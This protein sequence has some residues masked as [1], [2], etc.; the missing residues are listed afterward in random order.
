MR[1]DRVSKTAWRWERAD[2][3]TRLMMRWAS[4]LGLGLLG[5]GRAPL[6][7]CNCAE[8]HGVVI[9]EVCSCLAL[10]PSTPNPAG[11]R[12]F[13]L[14]G[15][16]EPDWAAIDGALA[17]GDV[18]VR[19][20]PGD[21]WERLRILRTDEGPHRLVLDGGG[22]AERATVAGIL[23]PFDEGPRHRITIR[24]FE[25]TGS[26]DKGVFWEAGDD[27]LIEDV[28]IHNNRG[29]PALNLEYSNRSGYPSTGFV[30]RNS[31][32]YDQRGECLYIGGAEGMDQDSHRDVRIENN[33]IHDCW[34]A[35]TKHDAINVK[36]RLSDVRVERNVVLRSDWGIEVASPGIYRNNLVMATVR[37]GVQVS[38]AF[39]PIRD[40]V[41]EG[42]VVVRPGHDGFHIATDRASAPGLKLR[43][44]WVVGARKAG[45]LL[46]SGAGM[47]VTIENMVILDSAVAFD[48]W[49]DEAVVDVV[50][51]QTSGN[52]E[53]FSRLLAE[54]GP[55]TTAEPVDV[56][57][58]AGP[59][60]QFFTADDPIVMQE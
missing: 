34:A 15:G 49:G 10:L 46:G 39:S 44:N 52:E 37:E 54:A 14:Q 2:I 28:V 20:A 32:I 53:D 59:D 4:V 16:A 6:E 50:D 40:M 51:C 31:H 30:V 60:G 33:L 56:T 38:D 57:T 36:D 7:V 18:V 12:E 8:G 29:T 3:Q 9:N 45:V 23:T 55:C 27:I 25:I 42:N 13:D 19:F 48:G 26:P 22:G 24:G 21:A 41:F 43:D 5:C 35:D 11:A 1:N 58:I 17:T 47:D